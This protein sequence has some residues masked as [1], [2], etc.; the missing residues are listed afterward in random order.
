MKPELDE[1]PTLEETIK[2]KN[3]LK[4]G[5]VAGGD[6][7]P[8]EIWK[9][10]G[11]TLRIKLHNLFVSC[12]EQGVQ[13]QDLCDAVIINIY[14]NKGETSDCSNYRGITLLSIARKILARVLLNRLVPSVTNPQGKSR[15][16][17]NTYSQILKHPYG[18]LSLFSFM[19]RSLKDRYIHISPYPICHKTLATI[20]SVLILTLIFNTCHFKLFTCSFNDFQSKHWYSTPAA[21]SVYLLSDIVST[22]RNTS[23]RLFHTLVCVNSSMQ[24]Q[25]FFGFGLKQSFNLQRTRR[26][27]VWHSALGIT[28]VWATSFWSRWRTINI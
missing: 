23:H 21:L 10:G 5:K 9:H 3:T 18:D 4:N 25:L 24:S 13:P 2:A 19:V 28:L 8:A 7:I 14:K 22:S 26:W 16:L 17:I 20:N 27:S 12:W 11:T 1:L 15:F 6:G